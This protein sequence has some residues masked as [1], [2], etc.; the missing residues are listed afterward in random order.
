[1]CTCVCAYIV[2]HVAIGYSECLSLVSNVLINF[3][4]PKQILNSVLYRGNISPLYRTYL[5]KSEH[6]SDYFLFI[7]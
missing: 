7:L 4:A 3:N 5:A 1:M 6:Q 2:E